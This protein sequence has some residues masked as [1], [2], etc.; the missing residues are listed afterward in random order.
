M[1]TYFH[2]FEVRWN[3]IDANRHLAN[4]SYVQYCAQARMSFMNQH[5]MGLSQLNRWGIGPV[6]L[7][8]KYSFY[9]EIYA[10]QEVY[11][12][13]EVSGCSE[14]ADIYSFV[15]HFY[16]ADGTHCASSEIIGIWID[17]M[18]R[19]MTM[20]PEEV[21]ECFNQFKSENAV[22]LTREDLRGVSPRPKNINPEV[23]LPQKWTKIKLR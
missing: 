13:L 8:E 3:D 5:K 9:K 16:L 18:L 23:F 15:H 19:K 2:K 4:S 12:S 17:M 21:K 22:V 11:V 10:D 20:P 7:H 14:N 6:I 1:G